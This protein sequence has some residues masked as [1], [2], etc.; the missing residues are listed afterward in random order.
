MPQRGRFATLELGF[1][2]ALRHQGLV[3]SSSGQS[4]LHCLNIYEEDLM[5]ETG[6]YADQEFQA[7]PAAADAAVPAGFSSFRMVSLATRAFDVFK[8]SPRD[9][10]WL[11]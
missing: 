6:K 8:V 11:V 4:A 2:L 1:G 7:Y 10:Y 9:Q 3:G 5:A